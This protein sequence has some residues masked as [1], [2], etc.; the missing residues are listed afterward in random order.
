MFGGTKVKSFG[1]TCVELQ[2]LTDEVITSE[3]TLSLTL[4][5]YADIKNIH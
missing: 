4:V 3:I 1:N 5:R 2:I